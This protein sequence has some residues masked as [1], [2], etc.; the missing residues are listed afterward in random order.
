MTK[1]LF[2]VLVATLFTSPSH[3]RVFEMEGMI[4]DDFPSFSFKPSQPSNYD[5]SGG[6]LGY[7][8]Y[9]RVELGPGMVESGFLYAPVSFT[10]TESSSILTRFAGS[11]WTIPLL[12]RYNFWEPYFS[13]AAGVD[14]AI[15]GGTTIPTGTS[16]N[17]ESHFGA[18][19]SLAAKQDIGEDLSIVLDLRYRVG[20]AT[21]A[22]YQ[23]TQMNVSWVSVAV[24]IEKHLE[25]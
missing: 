12:Y 6:G 2:T 11:Y 13:I 15:Q 3:A 20:L 4:Q 14:Y 19:A 24:G 16:N 21:G 1:I 17:Y 18:L 7:A 22:V 5:S 9:A 23:S 8:F 10:T 25:Y